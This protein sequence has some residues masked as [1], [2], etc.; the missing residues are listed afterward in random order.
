MFP[1]EKIFIATQ[2]KQINDASIT[3][4][5][6]DSSDPAT[7]EAIAALERDLKEMDKEKKVVAHPRT[8]CGPEIFLP[9]A[10]QTFEEDL[11][12]ALADVE[13]LQHKNTEQKFELERLRD[14]LEEAENAEIELTDN[15][16]KQVVKLV[17][18]SSP[19][20]E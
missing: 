13:D 10:E 18:V 11:E 1:S 14:Q 4:R 9:E 6:V 20:S 12:E 3:E 7:S 2:D 5:N 17:I 15:A 19:Y 16:N 8:R